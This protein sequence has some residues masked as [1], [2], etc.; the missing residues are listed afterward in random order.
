MPL[1]PGWASKARS[2]RTWPVSCTTSPNTP[3]ATNFA[4]LLPRLSAAGGAGDGSSSARALGD[5]STASNASPAPTA[6]RTRSGNRRVVDLVHQ[7]RGAQPHLVP[8]R[9]Q[10]VLDAL[11]V[12]EGAVAALQVH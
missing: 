3:P 4:T 11:A 2:K 9:Q 10:P 7:L 12:D 1:I 8:G 5:D 6:R